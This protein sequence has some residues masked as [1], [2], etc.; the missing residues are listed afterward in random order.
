[1]VAVRDQEYLTG[2]VNELCKLPHETEWV[3]FKENN[4]NPEMIG[5]DI[6]A[7]SNGAVL[8]GQAKAYIVWGIEDETHNPVGT[9]FIPGASKR[10]GE[11]L[12]NWLLRRISPQLNFAF[13][14]VE[15][16][17]KTIVILEIDATAQHPVAFGGERYIRV[18]SATK[19]LKDHPEKERTLWRLLERVNFENGLA[20]ER[21]TDENVLL[22]LDHPEY[23]NRL[24]LP[25]PDGRVAILDKLCSDNLIAR[26]PAGGWNI[27][28]LGAI[29][30]AR[31]IRN[32]PNIRRK[33]LRVIQY[34]GN[35]RTEA[36]REREFMAG[37]AISF[38][39]IVDYIMALVPA[40]ETIER[41]LREEVTMFPR[42][43]VRELVANAL[44]HQDYSI[45]GTGPM[46]E[47]FDTR[48]EITNPG[49]PLV[50]VE[51]FLDRPPRSRNETL[52]SLMR[53][54][55]ICEERGTGIDKVVLSVELHQ[56]PPPL[57]EAP[58]GSTRTFLFA[59]KPLSDMDR[60]ERVR[61][62]YL[63]AC[64]RYV[65]NQPM[66]NASIRDRFGIA[67]QNA[68]AASRFLREALDDGYIVIGNPDAGARS[69]A[70]LPYWASRREIG[71]QVL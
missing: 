22:K 46:V 49:E 12:E 57:F 13:G 28:N 24:K 67:R 52:A 44:I 19:K 23:F 30:L 65:T 61:A 5:A 29:L 40:T 27:S 9:A 59:R 3:E 54:F 14:G 39:E 11:L 7:L 64:L 6:A 70:Y 41:A 20:E 4:T 10:G 51:R 26:C 48:M 71:D 1:M 35:G 50:E 55:D 15:I 34:R 36:Q 42:I 2:L 62:C 56:S 18:G 53:R 38:D 47:I 66:N 60:P 8:S 17:G 37:Y 43:A 25:L 68:A 45:A 63:H 32:F 33:T 16:S 69:R 58:T 21:V 31:D